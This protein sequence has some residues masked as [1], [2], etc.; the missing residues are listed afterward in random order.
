MHG[1]RMRGSWWLVIVAVASMTSCSERRPLES[2]V[3]GATAAH[4]TEKLRQYH[5]QAGDEF[6]T[7]GLD[8]MAANEKVVLIHEQES[9]HA[10]GLTGRRLLTAFLLLDLKGQGFLDARD[11]LS[12]GETAGIEW[13]DVTNASKIP[14]EVDREG[15]V[16][17][18]QAQTARMRE[19]GRS[20]SGLIGKR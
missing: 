8:D 11:R 10:A 6:I 7:S 17:V 2:G 3:A 5:N 18:K 14:P 9:T 16:V 1:H 19:D 4:K 12:Q 20:M 15:I 13:S